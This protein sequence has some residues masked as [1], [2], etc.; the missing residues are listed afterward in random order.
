MVHEKQSNAQIKSIM[1]KYFDRKCW[2]CD[3]EFDTLKMAKIHYSSSH[4]NPNGFLSCCNLKLKTNVAVFDHIQWHIDPHTFRLQFKHL[5]FDRNI[6]DIF[7]KM[8]FLYEFPLNFSD[9]VYAIELNQN[10]DIHS[11]NM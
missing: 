11:L 4:R 8:S 3:T 10:I 9:V 7:L 5:I 2:Q 6:F 1:D